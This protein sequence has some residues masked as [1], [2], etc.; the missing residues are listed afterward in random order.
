MFMMGHGSQF[1]SFLMCSVS[2]GLLHIHRAGTATP[3]K[4]RTLLADEPGLQPLL[5]SVFPCAGLWTPSTHAPHPDTWEEG[6]RE[7][8]MEGEADG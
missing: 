1:M 4:A 3:A 8:G 7:G 2:V 6:G 5:S